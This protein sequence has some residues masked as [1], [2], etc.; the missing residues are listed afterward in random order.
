LAFVA[1]AL[2]PPILNIFVPQTEQ[3]PVSAFLPFF[4]VTAFSPFIS[5]FALHFTQ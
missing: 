1:P 2:P 4:M 5:R 3:V